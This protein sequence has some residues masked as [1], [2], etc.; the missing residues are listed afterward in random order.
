MNTQDSLTHSPILVLATSDCA[1]ALADSY[2]EYFP[3]PEPGVYINGNS[4]PAFIL[5][6]D[7]YKLIRDGNGTIV[8]S[9]ILS[10]ADITDTVYNL[11]AEIL[12]PQEVARRR[13]VSNKPS[14]PFIQAVLIKEI[15]SAAVRRHVNWYKGPKF[16][17]EDVIMS[18]VKEQIDPN[19]SEDQVSNLLD[20]IQEFTYDTETVIVKKVKND[21][22]AKFDIELRGLDIWITR[23][24][25]Y[26]AWDW[27]RRMASGEWE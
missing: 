22:W 21:P 9:K 27:E 13:M 2:G 23:G 10:I 3:K 24:M 6:Q 16:S 25:D 18:F 12:I 5:G 20:A 8:Q 4:K 7:C 26:R 14:L 1:V 11:D 17:T 19:A 15:A